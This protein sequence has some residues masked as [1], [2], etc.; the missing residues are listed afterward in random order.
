MATYLE[1]LHIEHQTCFR[2]ECIPQRPSR[3]ASGL[4][5]SRQICR[6]YMAMSRDDDA[7]LA[8]GQI[9]GRLNVARD[10]GRAGK[11]SMTTFTLWQGVT[12]QS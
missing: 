7:S 9:D 1:T 12:R 11:S 8:C 6:S 10:R 2:P 3:E 4:D 5:Y